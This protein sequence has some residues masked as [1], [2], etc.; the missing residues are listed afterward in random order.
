MEQLGF[1]EKACAFC[2]GIMAEMGNLLE[3]SYQKVN[4]ILFCWVEPGIFV[5][6]LFVFLW[7][8]FR[9]PGSR[10]LAWISLVANTLVILIM[11]V[12]LCI[13]TTMLVNQLC[14]GLVTPMFILNMN[15]TN[16]MYLNWYND[17]VQTLLH[18]GGKLGITYA[19]VNLLYYVLLL[20]MGII[21]CYWGILR[22]LIHEA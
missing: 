20:P 14:D 13:S 18:V 7:V 22:K 4:V 12:I 9:L 5:G 21:L 15:E 16:P 1:I 8:F 3:M 10:G 17:T 11:I 2:C 19:A 6:L